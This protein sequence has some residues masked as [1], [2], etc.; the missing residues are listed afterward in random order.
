M[1]QSWRCQ[2][3]VTPRLL[4]ERRPRQPNA[5]LKMRGFS[6][7]DSRVLQLSAE[8]VPAL[9]DVSEARMLI[10]AANEYRECAQA[11]RVNVSKLRDTT[12]MD[13]GH[14]SL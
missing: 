11:E 2:I 14:R 9:A 8:K 5:I 10:E 13:A 4:L 3:G 12:I 6:C 7:A 1:R